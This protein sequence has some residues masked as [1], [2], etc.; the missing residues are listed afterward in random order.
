MGIE[1][2]LAETFFHG[3]RILPVSCFKICLRHPKQSRA[4]GNQFKSCKTLLTKIKAGNKFE[5]DD[6]Y[7][8]IQWFPGLVQGSDRELALWRWFT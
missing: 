7:N 4:F 3:K 1:T 5:K 8:L 2:T 6:L